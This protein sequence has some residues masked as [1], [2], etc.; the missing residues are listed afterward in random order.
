[1]Q[2]NSEPVM[3]SRAPAAA[4]PTGAERRFVEF[5]YRHADEDSDE[6]A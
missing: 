3:R 6:I 5:L 1:M 4:R 2:V